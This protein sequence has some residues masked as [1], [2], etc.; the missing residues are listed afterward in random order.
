[1]SIDDCETDPRVASTCS[2]AWGVRSVSDRAARRAR[3]VIGSLFFNYH[4]GQHTFS[5]P[6]IDFASRARRPVSCALENARLYRVQQRIAETLQE[7]FIHELPSGR[8]P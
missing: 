5:E 1:M 6:E 8:R 2:I 3:Q 7:N 4:R